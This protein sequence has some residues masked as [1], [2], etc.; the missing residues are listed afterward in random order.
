[1]YYLCEKYHK[2]VAVKEKQKCQSLSRV[3]FFATPRTAAR[4]APLSVGFSRQE[5]QNGL[6]VPSPGNLSK[7]GIE[8]ESPTLQAD[9]SPSAQQ[10]S[11]SKL[12]V[13]EH[14]VACTVLSASLSQLGWT[15]RQTGLTNILLEWNLFLCRAVSVERET[16][17][18]MWV[19]GVRAEAVEW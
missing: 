19:L 5:Y 2:H 17:Q 12:V 6:P 18:E 3:P 11:P 8:P 16:R 4:Q 15:Y 9:S 7:P 13:A 1:M 10:G 14:C